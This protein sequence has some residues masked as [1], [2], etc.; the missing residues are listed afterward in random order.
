M[1]ADDCAAERSYL[2]H[3]LMTNGGVCRQ[4][5]SPTA[6]FRNDFLPR[7]GLV[8][9]L[10]PCGLRNSAQLK[11]P[12]MHQPADPKVKGRKVVILAT[13][14]VFYI[15]LLVN[16]FL[17]LNFGQHWDEHCLVDMVDHFYSTGTFI[18]VWYCYPSFC[19]FLT[20]FASCIFKW[21][22]ADMANIPLVQNLGFT[23]FL[24]GI[25]LCVSSLCVVWVYVLTLKITKKYWL[26]FL[27]GLIFCSSF[28]FSYHS[29][30]AVT[31]LVAV[32]FAFLSTLILF[33]DMGLSK[34]VLLSAFV[35]G[36]ATGTKYT[37]GI[38]GI[39][40]LIALLVD[41]LQTGKTDRAKTL[42]RYLMRA[43]FLFFIAFVLTTPGCLY[44][45]KTFLSSLHALKVEYAGGHVLCDTLN[46]GWEHFSKIM[47]YIAL[48]LFSKYPLVSFIISVLCLTG[49]GHALFNKR[50]DI[51][52]LFLSMFA[53]IAFVSLLKTMIV[54]NLLYVLPYFV[55]L[56]AYGLQALHNR[57]K[58]RNGILALDAPLIC[59]LAFSLYAIVVAS[60]S[61]YKKDAI[62]MKQDLALFLKEN[63]GNKYVFSNGVR[64]LLPAGY[65]PVNSADHANVL[66]VFLKNE[67]NLEHFSVIAFGRYKTIAGPT[68]INF[69]YYPDWSGPDRIV[70]INLKDANQKM[71]DDLGLR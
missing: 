44:H 45:L 25:F 12:P 41:S 20:L 24:R 22:H 47:V 59:L 46:P 21:F 26:A 37:A 49:T 7:L 53:Y 62:D 52:G 66:L 11:S 56:A 10:I 3:F 70:I 43:G 27:S 68:D 9:I 54:R 28:E 69:D 1:V 17:G 19:Y 48:S 57:I 14:V 64:Q 16:G 63:G 42:V 30:W 38:V 2:I 61:I 36:V 8:Q 50:W 67:V 29:R 31:D 58:K 39:N 51:F 71:L 18:P 15:F 13:P 32:Q 5:K 65:Q 55:V 35:A 4:G 6:G 40:I 33:L 34:R 23:L 60:W